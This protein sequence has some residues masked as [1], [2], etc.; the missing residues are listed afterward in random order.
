MFF[1]IPSRNRVF[2]TLLCWAKLPRDLL[3]IFKLFLFIIYILRN[4]TKLSITRSPDNK[5]H[6]LFVM[7]QL[8][9]SIVW[10]NCDGLTSFLSPNMH[11]I[12]T[13]KFTK[14]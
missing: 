13:K 11:R 10:Q 7:C 8:I 14:S 4:F 5:E 6:V 9:L 2:K 3:F 1:L 12:G